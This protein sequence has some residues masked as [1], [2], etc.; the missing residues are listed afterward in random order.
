[1]GSIYRSRLQLGIHQNVDGRFSVIAMGPFQDDAPERAADFQSWADGGWFVAAPVHG[2][3]DRGA[4]VTIE[5]GSPVA[6]APQAI[7]AVE[8]DGKRFKVAARWVY[9]FTEPDDWKNLDAWADAGWIVRD[10]T[11]N[12]EHGAFWVLVRADD[13]ATDPTG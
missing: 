1:M 10:T 13:A 3:G 5:K 11:G 2:N 9:G 8:K 4:Q 6:N 12:L 7:L